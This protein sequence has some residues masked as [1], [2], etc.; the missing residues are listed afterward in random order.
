MSDT[1]TQLQIIGQVESGLSA[2]EEANQ[3]LPDFETP[4]GYAEAKERKKPLTKARTTGDKARLAATK[5]LRD[6][7]SRINSMWNEQILPRIEAMEKPLVEGIKRVDDE[8]ARIEREKAEA[9]QRRIDEIQGRLLDIKHMQQAMSLE[10]I[11]ACLVEL[12]E[13]DFDAMF[14]EFA[15]TARSEAQSIRDLL[16]PRKKDLIAQA[17]EAARLEAQ[18]KEQEEKEAELRKQQEAIEA[19]Q[20]KL[21]EAKQAEERRKLR[22]EEQR[23]AQERADREKAEAVE[24]AKQ[25]AIE[26]ERQRV[27][28]E[29]IAKEQAEAAERQ[30]KADEEAEAARLAALAPDADKLAVWL[31]TVPPLPEMSSPEGK[32]M[33]ESIGVS[34]NEIEDRICAFHKTKEKAA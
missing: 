28:N 11:D 19:E 33:S 30:R 9:E 27:E 2:L 4:E 26:E 34:I 8:K 1:E 24:K 15:D 32:E 10:Q 21:E 20:R 29:R 13:K 22:E 12:N 16:E 7:V 3:T 14:Q 25:K 6:E 23:K 18:R 31:L 17:E 5:S